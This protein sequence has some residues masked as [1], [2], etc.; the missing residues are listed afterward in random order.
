MAFDDT[1]GTAGGPFA[2][3][4]RTD[5]PLTAL[6]TVRLRMLVWIRWCAV[7]GQLAT[8]LIVQY[9]L[10]LDYSM[11]LPV[12]IVGA[13]AAYNLSLHLQYPPTHRLSNRA[14]M[15]HMLFDQLQLMA[16]LGLTGGIANP[17]TVLMVVPATVGAITLP[18]WASLRLFAATVMGATLIAF[19][20]RPLPWGDDPLVLNDTYLAGCWIAVMTTVSFLAA[21]VAQVSVEAR[22]RD[23]AYAT[24]ERTL[25]GERQ[26]SALGALSAA[27]AHELGTPLGTI[28]LAAREITQELDPADPLYEEAALIDTQATRCRDILKRMTEAGRLDAPSS[29]FPFASP[30]ALMREIVGP[31]ESDERGPEIAIQVERP[32][33]DPG[34]VPVIPRRPEIMQA[35]GNFVENATD[36]ARDRVDVNIRWDR[37]TLAIA[38]VDDGPG[39]DATILS[40]LGEPYVSNRRIGSIE[41][42]EAHGAGG[43]GLGIFIAKTLLE[44]TGA[45]VKFVNSSGKGA[46]VDVTWPRSRL[47]A[48]G[49]PGPSGSA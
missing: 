45:R 43:L 16:L 1:A 5:D 26:L 3:W 39:F 38:I 12:A 27:A 13:T 21:Y 11:A 25:A 23:R 20:Y 7:S 41:R 6:P 9:G 48:Q 40:H 22:R 18:R 28:K 29:P 14:A 31:Y 17:F 15:L 35:L 46:R 8:L 30:E 10:G 44:R 34:A 2:P 37:D 32:D 33:L 19:V 4:S 24:L 36:F 47:D 42:A 49:E